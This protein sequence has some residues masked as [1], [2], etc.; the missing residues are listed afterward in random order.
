MKALY[1]EMFV[2]APRECLTSHKKLSCSLPQE[3]QPLEYV[4]SALSPS[5]VQYS[6]TSR[7]T[8]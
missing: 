8:S 5:E 4:D 3:G 1:P 2:K 7:E 6:N